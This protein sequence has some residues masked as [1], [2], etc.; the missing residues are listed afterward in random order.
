MRNLHK[1]IT[2]RILE[3][4]KAGVVPWRQPWSGQGAGGMPRNAIT[5]RAYSGVNVVLLWS[6]AQDK[7]YK[8]PRWLTYKQA[9]E[10]GGQVRKGEHGVG[11][12]FVSH[13]EA[14]RDGETRRVPFLKSYVVFNVAQCDGLEASEEARR[15]VNQDA[16]DE[17]ADAFIAA[18][19]CDVRHGE[20][21]AYYR[22]AGDFVMMPDFESF[23][24]AARYYGVCFHELTHWTGA[25]ARLDR[26]I[27]NR[28]G[29]EGY[30]AEELVAELG[31]AFCCAEFGFDSEGADAAYIAHWIKFLE[32]HEKALVM[33]SAAASK[34]VEFMRGQ[35][36]A[37]AMATA[38]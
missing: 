22:P 32:S 6:E 4:L 30:S 21:R 24:N 14:E 15:V 26:Q 25:K 33:A 35:A 2:D 1:E 36:M 9:S 10:A 13:F 31:S 12:V 23:K 7:G 8:S 11:I 37:D 38:A 5:G 28:F 29:D 18:T 17:L 34:A 27:A 16:R 19:G 3:Q 20:A